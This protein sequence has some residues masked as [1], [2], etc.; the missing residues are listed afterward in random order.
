MGVF[1]KKNDEDVLTKHLQ[2]RI[3]Y[4]WGTYGKSGREPLKFKKIRDMETE[5]IINVLCTQHQIPNMY[6]IIFLNELFLRYK[7][8]HLNI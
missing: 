8:P 7:Q 6:K 2:N 3:E 1:T 4:Q 5:H